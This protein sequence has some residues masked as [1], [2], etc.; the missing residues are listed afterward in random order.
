MRWDLPKLLHG[1][2][3]TIGDMPPNTSSILSGIILSFAACVGLRC[4]ITD[5]VREMGRP[6]RVD[7]QHIEDTLI[8]QRKDN[9]RAW[10]RG[11]PTQRVA[12]DFS[13]GE[14]TPS[15]CH[16]ETDIYSLR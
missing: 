5:R 13:V 6:V 16:S 14:T 3:F 4:F 11:G 2:F 1:N 12:P 9:E 7:R 8:Q 15:A 10:L